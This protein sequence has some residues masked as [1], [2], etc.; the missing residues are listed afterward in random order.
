MH[1]CNEMTSAVMLLRIMLGKVI[2][3]VD[4]NNAAI[5]M[6]CLH[7]NEWDEVKSRAEITK[8]QSWTIKFTMLS[9]MVYTL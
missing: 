7:I 5:Y 8:G 4:N 2:K 3:A 1:E 6:N 9:I